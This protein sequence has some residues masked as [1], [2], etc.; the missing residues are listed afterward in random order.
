MKEKDAY[1]DITYNYLQKNYE[2][3]NKLKILHKDVI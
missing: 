3:R 2:Q 1:N